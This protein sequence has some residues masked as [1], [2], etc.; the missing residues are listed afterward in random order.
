MAED[1][2]ENKEKTFTQ[3]DIDALMNAK[4]HERDE[5]KAAEAKIKELETEIL[6][7]KSK[8]YGDEDK[9]KNSPL[10]KNMEIEFNK[11]QNSYNQASSELTSLKTKL[12]EVDLGK[13]LSKNDKILPSAIDD[14]LLQMREAGFQKTEKGWLGKNGE[15]VNDFVTN[16]QNTKPHYFKRSI[17]SSQYF[18]KEKLKEMGDRKDPRQMLTEIFSR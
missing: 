17:G 10:F 4:N 6:N 7:I 16:L 5:R 3:A 14:I 9:I 1:N 15:N 2:E 12:D 18:T 11:L 13:E 8:T